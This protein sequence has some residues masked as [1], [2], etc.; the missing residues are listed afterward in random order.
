MNP[1]KFSFH[2][3][4]LWNKYIE[5]KYKYRLYVKVGMEPHPPP[6]ISLLF[7][8]ILYLKVPGYVFIPTKNYFKEIPTS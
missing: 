5:T 4:I 8:S 6:N 1:L 2:L 7:A 3:N